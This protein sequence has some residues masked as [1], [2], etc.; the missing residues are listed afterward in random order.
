MHVPKE[1]PTSI[2]KVW[3]CHMWI[4]AQPYQLVPLFAPG[5]FDFKQVHVLD[6]FEIFGAVLIIHVIIMVPANKE[7][8]TV[9]AA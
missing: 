4:V 8:F 9:Q 5:I 7:L 3:P 2:G 6:P 1:I